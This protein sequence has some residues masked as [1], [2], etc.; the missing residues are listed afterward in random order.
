MIRNDLPPALVDNPV[1]GRW[2]A[3]DAP[4]RVRLGTGKVELGQGVLTALVQMAAEELDVSPSRID[5]VSGRTGTSPEEGFTAGSQSIEASGAAIRVAS[6]EVRQILVTAAA[7]RLGTG[8]EALA[9]DD[10]RVLSDGVATAFDYWN[11]MP[12]GALS[13]TATGAAPLR[14]AGAFRL[15][16]TSLP[17]IDLP[18]KLAG[19]AFIQDLAPADIL[20]VRVLRVPRRGAVPIALDEDGFRRRMEGRAELLRVGNFIAVCSDDEA[21]VATA[22][23]SVD[24]ATTWSP[25][26]ESRPEHGEAAWLRSLRTITRVVD[27]PEGSGA[28]RP[29]RTTV[30]A[31][32]TRPY[33][34][35]GSIGTCCALARWDGQR[36]VVW[37]HSQGVGPLR[38]S[39]A[40]AL[41]LDPGRVD[42][43]HQQGAGCYGHNGAD[44]VALDA[45]IVALHRPNRT[46]RALWTREQELS[47]GPLGAAASVSLRAGQDEA[48]RPTSWEIE[49]W[50]P[51]HGRRPGMNGAINLL[52]HEALSGV[53]PEAETPDVP[54]AAGGGGNRNTFAL[55]DLPKQRIV[56][57]LVQGAP[58]RTSSLRGLGAQANVMA[59]E[60]FM[61]EMALAAGIDPVTYRLSL[62]SDPRARGVIE[63]AAALCDWSRRGA[64]GEGE[65][66]GFAFSRYKNKAAYVAAAVEVQ[67]DEDV[68]VSRVWC[69]VDAGLVI[70]PD[71]ARN[72]IEGG[73]LQAVSWTL[74][75][76][77]RVDGSGIVSRTWDTYP[78]LK[79][80]EA[81]AVDIALIGSPSDPPLGVGEVVLGPTTAGIM[82]AVAHAIGL[83]IRDLPLTRQRL[84]ETMLS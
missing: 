80:S 65:G 56:H 3:F 69:A 9:V 48:G 1:L 4:G 10:G 23:A 46:V 77:V 42:V 81:P 55:Y 29:H 28:P 60:S 74:K 16:G 43:I 6:A 71:G 67:V 57:H 49:V 44:D 5:I 78:I 24:R 22:L 51:T 53:A 2:V 7:E 50:S 63:K 32:Y 34:A 70:N 19:A 18:A 66:L 41:D 15:I 82:N 14:A 79:F 59:I 37:T 61:D 47:C 64:G 36:L 39:L 31:T 73:V 27:T 58:L 25:G 84:V 8:V 17:R 38:R 12:A 76:Q 75:E 52:A 26:E 11:C 30:E 20:H 40:L 13:R 68:R 33:L 35:H 62:M 54:D 83:R 72:Q 45:G 21:A